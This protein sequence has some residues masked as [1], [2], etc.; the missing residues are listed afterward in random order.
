MKARFKNQFA[1]KVFEFQ[2]SS[3]IIELGRPKDPHNF[4][5]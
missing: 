3:D 1:K 4:W 2:I 5:K